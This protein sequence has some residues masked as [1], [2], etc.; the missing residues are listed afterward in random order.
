MNI[1]HLLF[2]VAAGLVAGT[3]NSIA[4]GGSLISFPALLFVGLGPIVANV[5]NSL[6]SLPGYISG[7]IGYR[8]AL[9]HQRH[10]LIQASI[11][12]VFGSVVGTVILLTT[13]VSYFR[14]VVPFLILGACALLV[15]QE[16][17]SVF[18]SFSKVSSKSKWVMPLAIG[19]SAIYG[20]YFGAG[21]GIILLAILSIF[22]DETLQNNNALKI[23]LSVVIASVGDLIYVLVTHVAFLDAGVMAIGFILGGFLGAKIASRLSARVLRIS[24]VIF[25]VCVSSILLYQTYL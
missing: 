8:R 14:A 23:T 18:V 15:F 4:G 25:G 16:R 22:S 17:I 6:A 19:I 10:R 11:A 5:T 20:S 2:L 1:A 3:V 9:P 13:P 24:I 7:T 21:L 12:C